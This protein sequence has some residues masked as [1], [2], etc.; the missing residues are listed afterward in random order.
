[1]DVILSP[2]VGEYT[3]T[4]IDDLLIVSS[5]FEEHLGQV[6]QRL[7]NA[8][9]TLNLEKSVF[10]QEKVTFLGRSKL[11]GNFDRPW[12]G[13]RYSAVPAPK[14]RKQLR[15]F[16]GLCGYYRRFCEK[17]SHATAPLTRLLRKD[18]GWCWAT[19]E[20]TAFE[21]T[22]ELFLLRYLA[23]KMDFVSFLFQFKIAKNKFK[24]HRFYTYSIHGTR[25]YIDVIFNFSSLINTSDC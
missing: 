24:S 18:V 21:R 6:L 13:R 15:A 1:M 16:L 5:S 7:R 17:Y 20:H 22:K 8:G 3:I 4:Y 2:E 23:G 9:T 25:T 12:Q 10:L 14:T 11:P 19:N